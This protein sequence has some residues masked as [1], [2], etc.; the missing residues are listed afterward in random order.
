MYTQHASKGGV[1]FLGNELSDH[2][3]NWGAFSLVFDRSFLSPP[4]GTFSQ[5]GLPIFGKLKICEFRH[6]LSRNEHNNIA[7]TPIYDYYAYSSPF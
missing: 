4:L 5:H 6:P 7:V 2:Y 3:A 1:G